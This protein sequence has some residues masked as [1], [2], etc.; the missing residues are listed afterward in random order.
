MELNAREMINILKYDAVVKMA[1]GFIFFLQAISKQ[2]YKTLL[3]KILKMLSLATTQ[4]ISVLQ[5]TPSRQ[6]TIPQLVVRI[7]ARSSISRNISSA[8]LEG[9]YIFGK[10]QSA[11][12]DTAQFKSITNTKSAPLHAA[13]SRLD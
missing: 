5:L 9:V 8:V 12:T 6:P 13:G 10:R 11:H 7:V 1:L 4:C 3:V 2:S